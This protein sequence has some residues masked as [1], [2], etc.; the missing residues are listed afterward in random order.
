MLEGADSQNQP[1][2]VDLTKYPAEEVN[3]LYDVTI[4]QTLQ[5]SAT[6]L[7]GRVQLTIKAIKEGEPIETIVKLLHSL[8]RSTVHNKDVILNVRNSNSDPRHC[9]LDLKWNN[10]AD[11]T[12]DPN[13]LPQNAVIWGGELPI[14]QR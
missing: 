14:E 7:H 3:R 13:K 1:H 11:L 6:I 8:E 5:Q 2:Y 10:G 4:E 9:P 12:D